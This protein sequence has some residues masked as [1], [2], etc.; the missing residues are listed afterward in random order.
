MLKMVDQVN[1]ENASEV[2]TIHEEARVLRL[3]PNG[4]YVLTGGSKGDVCIWHVFRR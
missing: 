4:R 3:C 2:G 1:T